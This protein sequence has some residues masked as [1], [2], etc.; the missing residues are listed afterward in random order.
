MH[1]P[2][3]QQ[4]EIMRRRGERRSSGQ[5]QEPR[6]RQRL[7][8]AAAPLSYSTLYLNKLSLSRCGLLT[9]VGKMQSLK[10][11][12]VDAFWLFR[13]LFRLRSDQFQLMDHGGHRKRLAV[14]SWV[15]QLPKPIEYLLV[16][17]VSSH[18]TKHRL[19]DPVIGPLLLLLQTEWRSIRSRLSVR[20]RIL[21]LR[22]IN[23]YIECLEEA[24]R[25]P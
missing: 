11:F 18:A 20:A 4:L 2:D 9:C 23:S 19:F 17:L 14:H 3:E 6:R 13:N 15:L 22:K 5:D 1:H 21:M 25:E 7:G 24:D 12:A 8:A 16:Y 10:T